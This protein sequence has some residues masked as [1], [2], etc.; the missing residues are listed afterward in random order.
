MGLGQGTDRQGEGSMEGLVSISKL[1]GAV[2]ELCS[3]FSGEGEGRHREE[4][5]HHEGHKSGNPVRDE[6]WRRRSNLQATPASAFTIT[7]DSESGNLS[8]TDSQELDGEAPH[9]TNS[10]EESSTQFQSDRSSRTVA[11]APAQAASSRESCLSSQPTPQGYDPGRLLFSLSRS[12]GPAVN[13]QNTPSD[14][15]HA[16]WGVVHSMM[17]S[18]AVD[19]FSPRAGQGEA[20]TDLV[21]PTTQPGAGSEAGVDG[22]E[23]AGGSGFVQ[24][25][26]TGRWSDKRPSYLPDFV[27]FS[28]S[29]GH[30]SLSVRLHQAV[31]IGDG[32]QLYVN[33]VAH[34]V[35]SVRVVD[36]VQKGVIVV[37]DVRL[38]VRLAD[39]A[40]TSVGSIAFFA[41]PSVL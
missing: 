21:S 32:V 8:Q 14:M 41:H 33:I 13:D 11:L 3:E 6:C 37:D 2:S 31:G 17:K 22:G 9:R 39:D 34:M 18:D 10:L 36:P 29:V 16:G 4:G 38:W 40:P 15:S 35:F 20:V 24:K 7:S 5:W 27:N 1:Q 26:P 19:L 28:V 23:G 25:R 30:V 12:P